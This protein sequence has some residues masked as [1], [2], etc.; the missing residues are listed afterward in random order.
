MC[1]G[2]YSEHAGVEKGNAHYTVPGAK[3][4]QTKSELTYQF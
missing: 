1:A 4:E 3:L 2:V